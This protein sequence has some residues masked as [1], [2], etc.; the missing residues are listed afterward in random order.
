MDLFKVAT[1]ALVAF[2][3]VVVLSELEKIVTGRFKN[4]H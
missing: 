2:V 1:L 3:E 4:G